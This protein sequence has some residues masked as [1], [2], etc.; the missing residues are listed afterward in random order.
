MLRRSIT[1]G[2]RLRVDL[3]DVRCQLLNNVIPAIIV[4][5]GI[6]N[7]WAEVALCLQI[8]KGT[9]HVEP[10]KVDGDFTLAKK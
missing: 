10:Y 1:V 4:R 6:R 2:E 5:H 9:V 8:S 3:V 7:A